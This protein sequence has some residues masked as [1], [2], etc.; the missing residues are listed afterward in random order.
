MPESLGSRDG[1]TV[2]SPGGADPG[3]GEKWILERAGFDVFRIRNRA[4]KYW[5]ITDDEMS[6]IKLQQNQGSESQ[7]WR[8]IRSMEDRERL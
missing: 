1:D 3:A 8:L 7:L 5:T 6:P 4:G 2:W